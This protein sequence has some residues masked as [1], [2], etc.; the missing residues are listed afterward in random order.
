MHSP[1]ANDLLFVHPK[2]GTPLQFNITRIP[3]RSKIIEM[4][5]RGGGIIAD[6]P[7]QN[8]ISVMES[9]KITTQSNEFCSPNF[10]EY[11]VNNSIS[12]L[13]ALNAENI[14]V[15]PKTQKIS[16][17]QEIFIQRSPLRNCEKFNY[18]QNQTY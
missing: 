4:I 5:K 7:E 2:T 9:S 11:C 8:V 14:P 6:E 12:F 3:Q 1:N 15:S 10:I 17:S 13:D 18:S 16:N